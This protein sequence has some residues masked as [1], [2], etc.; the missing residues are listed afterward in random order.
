MSLGFV[1]DLAPFQKLFHQVNAAPG[2]VTLVIQFLIGGAGRGAKTT[3]HA[4][5]KDGFRLLPFSGIG[6]LFNQI[7]LHRGPVTSSCISV[8][9]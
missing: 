4:A 1:G 3:M 9:D 2:P 6:K 8:R 7:G 5:T